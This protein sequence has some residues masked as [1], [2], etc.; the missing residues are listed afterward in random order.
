MS[1]AIGFAVGL[2]AGG[3]GM[4]AAAWVAARARII[5][6]EDACD[7]RLAEQAQ[8]HRWQ[9]QALLR[10]EGIEFAVVRSAD[11]ATGAV[12]ADATVLPIHRRRTGGEGA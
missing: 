8:L 10:G 9:M 4:R 3:L 7:R 1:A 6:T 12:I 5:E 11:A 2:V